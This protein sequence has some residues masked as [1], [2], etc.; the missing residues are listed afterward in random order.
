MGGKFFRLGH[1]GTRHSWNAITDVS[2][3]ALDA[4]TKTSDF[5]RGSVNS[6][7][8]KF[9]NLLLVLFQF[10]LEQQNG[11][12]GFLILFLENL[13]ESEI[14]FVYYEVCKYRWIHNVGIKSITAKYTHA[15][16]PMVLYVI[17]A[18]LLVLRYVSIVQILVYRW[19]VN[20]ILN[21][22]KKEKTCGSCKNLIQWNPFKMS[23][24]YS[25]HLILIFK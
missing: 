2:T 9:S 3:N 19:Y 15:K 5:L 17:G 12:S 13:I 23:R 4:L 25:P 16:M 11:L 8:L 18:L 7:L 24:L 20:I 14:K 22:F 21:L 10:L 6:V 1:D